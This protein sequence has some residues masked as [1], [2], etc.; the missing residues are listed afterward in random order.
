MKSFWK[1]IFERESQPDERPVKR[2]REPLIKLD[3]Y[4]T[5][6]EVR[7]AL[8]ATNERAAGPVGVPLACLKS[9]GPGKLC[10]L[11]NAV[12]CGGVLPDKWR[13]ARTVLIPK[14]DPPEGPGDFRPITIG[15]YFYRLYASVIGRR[16]RDT[17]PIAQRQ[18]GFVRTD[19]I[20]DNLMV[21]KALVNQTY[22][23]WM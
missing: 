18:K 21:M 14:S 17:I 2:A 16:I 7:N 11:Y 23:S 15:G 9:I 13:H 3:G 8:A 6:E 4:I 12:Y 5:T 10:I 20:R 22:P 19:G 1:R